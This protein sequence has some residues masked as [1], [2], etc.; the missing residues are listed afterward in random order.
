MNLRR[1]AARTAVVGLSTTLAAGALVAGATIAAN[2]AGG[3]ATY[4]CVSA[5]A[6]NQPIPVKVTLS[7]DT[8]FVPALPTGFK[9]PAGT[10][11][12]PF[13]F[14]I[15]GNAARGMASGI[16]ATKIGTSA[17]SFSL[18][19]G[20]ANIP[21]NGL[22]LAQAAIP[23][24]GDFNLAVPGAGASQGEFALPSPGTNIP[25]TMPTTFPMTVVSDSPIAPSI[26]VTCTIQGTSP[27]L[28]TL[29]VTKQG[30]TIGKLKAP[31]SV[32]AGKKF[33]IVAKVAGS[34]VPATGKVVAKEGKK[35][36]GKG[37]LKNGKASIVVK[38]GIKK[39]GKHTITISYAGDKKTNAASNPSTVAVTV[40]A[41]K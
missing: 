17:V 3:T 39:A 11:S 31:K 26:P 5:L 8:S 41:K 12:M 10:L 2:A 35:V 18:P 7:A 21:L 24:T 23:A 32:K 1:L 22:D 20:D 40:K 30:S 4:S 29:T 38:K 27:T 16:K 37:T 25:V 19:F 13:T 33:S 34:N 9:A 28:A 36:L 14:S 6:P 15:D